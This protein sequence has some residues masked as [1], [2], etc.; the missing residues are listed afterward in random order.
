MRGLEADRAGRGAWRRGAAAEAYTVATTTVARP[1]GARTLLANESVT[2]VA[3][4]SRPSPPSTSG[5]ALVRK[6]DLLFKLDDAI[7]APS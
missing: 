3:E 7:C 5:G 1:C 6:G 4:S 2:I